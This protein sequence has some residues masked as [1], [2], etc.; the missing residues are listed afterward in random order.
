MKKYK[1][2]IEAG[3]LMEDPELRL[4]NIQEIEAKNI[5]EAKKKYIKKNQIDKSPYYDSKKMSDW[6]WGVL[7]VQEFY[8]IK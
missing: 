8:K 5:L 3:G 1:I 6:G 7:T 2:G 4:T